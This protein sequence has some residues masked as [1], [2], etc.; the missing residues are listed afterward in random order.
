MIRLIVSSRILNNTNENK[1]LQEQRGKERP[2]VLARFMLSSHILLR[3]AKTECAE[4]YGQQAVFSQLHYN[5][6]GQSRDANAICAFPQ[7]FVTQFR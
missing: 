7:R 5:I 1:S 2:P 3:K 6:V 4:T